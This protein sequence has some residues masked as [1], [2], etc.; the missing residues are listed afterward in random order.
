MAA[1]A[2]IVL[3]AQLT[4]LSLHA[5]L[6]SEYGPILTQ[7]INLRRGIHSSFSRF[8]TALL[9]ITRF[10]EVERRSWTPGHLESFVLPTFRTLQLPEVFLRVDPI[11]AL[12]S[13]ISKSGCNLHDC[14]A[15]YRC[16]AISS[17]TFTSTLREICALVAAILRAHRHCDIVDGTITPVASGNL[18]KQHYERRSNYG[19]RALA[20]ANPESL[21]RMIEFQTS[22]MDSDDGDVVVLRRSNLDMDATSAGLDQFHGPPTASRFPPF[23]TLYLIR[24]LHV[25]HTTRRRSDHSAAFLLS[26]VS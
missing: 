24:P 7:S 2:I 21:G 1:S 19:S 17:S 25:K 26:V 15:K 23:R 20:A 6:P 9:G 18:A 8:K 12:V 14:L 5:I 3:W 22:A 4:S 10:R 13:F 11:G 16:M